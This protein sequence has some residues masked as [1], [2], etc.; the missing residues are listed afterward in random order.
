LS[1]QPEGP[2]IW[3]SLPIKVF[4]QL[5]STNVANAAQYKALD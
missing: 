5:S 3:L 1:V 2:W 4:A